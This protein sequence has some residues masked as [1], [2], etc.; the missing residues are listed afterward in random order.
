MFIRPGKNII[1]SEESSDD[2]IVNCRRKVINR[3]SSSSN[4]DT[5]ESYASEDLDDML[6]ELA[7]DEEEEL[8]SVDD[9]LDNIQWNEFA[10]RQQTFTF[11]G[12]SGLLMDLPSDISASEVLSLFLDE[13]VISLLVTEPN[14]YAEQKL[15]QQKMTEHAR[16]N[17]WKPTTSAEIRKFIGLLI[18]MGL[19]Q[20]PLVR[21]W[22]MDPIYMYSFPFPRS[23]MSRNRFE[24]L[25]ANL[26][27]ANNETIEEGSR[28]GKVLPLLNLLTDNYQ[29]VF[30]P[31]EDIVIDETMVP[32]R[33]AIDI[34]TIYTNKIS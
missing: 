25:L 29:K 2:E 27:F 3:I 4:S 34:Q 20:T 33:G 1:G 12:K 24:L 30:S 31:G 17:R 11:T 16:L 10:N 28:L 13:K 7:L 32:W 21:C 26:D 15:H 22:S 18:W 6:E 14:K 23:K 19:V 5:E 9:P 8:N